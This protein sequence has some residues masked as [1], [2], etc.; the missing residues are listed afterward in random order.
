MD[1][2]H[3]L[4]AAGPISRS[5]FSGAAEGGTHGVCTEAPRAVRAASHVRLECGD[6]LMLVC[7]NFLRLLEQ[8]HEVAGHR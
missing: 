4:K 7:D 5:H 8:Q 3:D 6:G 1:R 2:L